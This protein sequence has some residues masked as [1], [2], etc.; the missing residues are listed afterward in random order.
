[1]KDRINAAVWAAIAV[2]MIM[3]QLKHWSA[4]GGIDPASVLIS[5]MICS[6]LCIF[7]YEICRALIDWK[8]SRN[9]QN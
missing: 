4:N 5:V 6:V 2:L 3:L 7:G 1:M 9:S 8:N